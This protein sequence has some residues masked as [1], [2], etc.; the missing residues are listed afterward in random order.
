[1]HTKNS[2]KIAELLNFLHKF[3]EVNSAR[4]ADKTFRYFLSLDISSCKR[5]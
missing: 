1:M 5:L 2:D 3:I 4:E